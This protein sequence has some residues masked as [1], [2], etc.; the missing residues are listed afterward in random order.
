MSLR[1]KRQK[2]AQ[3]AA[4]A[5]LACLPPDGVAF[6]WRTDAAAKDSKRGGCDASSSAAG[7]G[8]STAA[9]LAGNGR[10][11]LVA[12]GEDY[13]AI[14]VDSLDSLEDATVALENEAAS[15][16]GGWSVLDG[17]F[18]IVSSDAGKNKQR[19]AL[20]S[21][22]AVRSRNV[23]AFH[24]PAL[25]G[26]WE[27]SDGRYHVDPEKEKRVERFFDFLKRSRVVTWAGRAAD[28]PALGFAL[29]LLGPCSGFW[30][31]QV[32]V[33]G[34]IRAGEISSE[35]PRGLARA[36]VEELG[37][38]L[39]KAF[40]LA[41]WGLTPKPAM[42]AYAA[43]DVIITE[44][45]YLRHVSG[46]LFASQLHAPKSAHELVAESADKLHCALAAAG[47]DINNAP[48]T[49]NALINLIISRVPALATLVEAQPSSRRAVSAEVKDLLSQALPPWAAG[50]P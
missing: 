36:A 40:Q 46:E 45:L 19:M 29:P 44:R 23:Y 30:D 35:S 18:D 43:T 4:A 25:F 16:G 24:F 47:A 33:A 10:V 38:A 9:V 7:G 5:P 3:L 14:L 2:D 49:M 42:I 48:K 26:S 12:L 27:K 28:E 34:R 13:D 31:L 8:G 41:P 20:L 17:E 50:L 15:Q 37:V 39:D 21:M 22:Q 32:H 1:A 11:H 6:C